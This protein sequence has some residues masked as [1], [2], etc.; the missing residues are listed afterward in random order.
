MRDRFP[1]D[2]HQFYERAGAHFLVNRNARIREGIWLVGLDDP[3]KGWPS[4]PRA[5]RGIPNGAFTIALIHAP[6]FFQK[7]TGQV[8]LILA[9][10]THGGQIHLPFIRPFWLPKGSGAFLAGWYEKNGTRMYVSRGIGNTIMDARFLC[11][12]EIA[13]ITVG[14]RIERQETSFELGL[15]ILR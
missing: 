11:R 2:E 8:N 3:A 10:H 5:L 13:I 9:G 1:F 15:S 4:A 12:P 7:L 14:P 6:S